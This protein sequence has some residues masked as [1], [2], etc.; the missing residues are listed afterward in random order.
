VKL[1]NGTTE[2]PINKSGKRKILVS[3][4]DFGAVHPQSE[5]SHYLRND[6]PAKMRPCLARAILQLYG[7]SPVL[8]PMAGLGTTLVEAML[9]GMDAIGVEYEKKFADQANKNIA[10]IKKLCPGKNLGRAVCNKGDARDLSCLNKPKVRSI[11]FSPP[12]SEGIGHTAGKN[13]SMKY[14]WRLKLQ[15]R[16]TEPWTDGSI[17]KLRYGDKSFGSIFF[18]PP[19]FNAVESVSTGHQGPEGGHLER[20]H[21]LAKDRKAGYGNKN[22]IGH[23]KNYGS[24][25]F[26]PPYSNALKRGDEGPY[27][28]SKRISYEDRLKRFQGYSSNSGNI[29]NIT[30]FGSVVFSPPYE[31][32]LNSSKHVGGI[33]SRDPKLAKTGQYSDDRRNI[34]NTVGQTY[35]GEMLKVYSE[36]YRVLKPGKFM[37]VV[38]KDIQRLWKT[39]PIGADTIKLCQLAGF[40]LHDIIVNRMY[41]PSF[42]MLNLAKKSQSQRNIGTKKFHALKTHEYVLVFRKP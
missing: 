30:Q 21:R 37:V 39:I 34:G 24:I 16:M 40:D 27:S 12:Y 15:K 28:G 13:A 11:V 19:Y 29:G 17:A 38:V 41:F 33:A 14:P 32:A 36:C 8:D 26:P 4:W 25:I 3:V 18:S 6:H 10:H 2:H 23:A 1:P 35:L 20:Q 7:E 31:G 9:L 42:W 5:R 22:N